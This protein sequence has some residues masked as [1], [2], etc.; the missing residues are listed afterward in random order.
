M[1][2]RKEPISIGDVMDFVSEFNNL[3]HD[4]IEKKFIFASNL[5]KKSYQTKST[6]KIVQAIA[7]FNHRLKVKLQ[8]GKKDLIRTWFLFFF[9]QN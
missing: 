7:Q 1:T 3:N 5:G 8:L 9:C 6:I 4:E 2:K